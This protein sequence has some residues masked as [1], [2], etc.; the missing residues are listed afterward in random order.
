M[1][2]WNI[3][4]LIPNLIGYARIF[5]ILLAFFFCFEQHYLFLLFYSISQLLDVLD[6]YAARYFRQAT[7]YGAVLDMVTDRA[8]TAALLI[9]M[10]KVYPQYA[11]VFMALIAL[12]IVSHF[13]HVASALIQGKQSH[14]LIGRGQHW[15][16]RLYYTHKAV[17]FTLCFGN[18]AFLLFLYLLHLKPSF[19]LLPQLRTII[20]PLLTYALGALFVLKQ[21]VNVIQLIKAGQDLV[22]FDKKERKGA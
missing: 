8:S 22:R 20:L 6:G 14:K 7:K 5:F 16:L 2:Q 4:L 9:A 3:Y 10:T 19:E 13:A 18:E 17:L 21:F 11:R 1:S 15:L 12:D